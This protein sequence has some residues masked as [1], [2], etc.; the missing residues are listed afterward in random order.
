MRNW[1]GMGKRMRNELRNRMWRKDGLRCVKMCVPHVAAAWG[2]RVGAGL[3][4]NMHTYVLSDEKF[5]SSGWLKAIFFLVLKIGRV[6][7]KK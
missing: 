1:I 5:L 6:S 7:S 2:R 4:F 3:G